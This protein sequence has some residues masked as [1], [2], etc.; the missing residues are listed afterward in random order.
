[1][2][3]KTHY[4]D[5][6]TR[7]ELA[8]RVDLTEARVQVNTTIAVTVQPCVCVCVCVCLHVSVRREGEREVKGGEGGK[9][10]RDSCTVDTRWGAAKYLWLIALIIR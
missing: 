7:E 4:P 1:M 6:F 8:Q 10:G 2:F 9:S 3:E 5:V